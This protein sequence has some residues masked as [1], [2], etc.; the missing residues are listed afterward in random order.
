MATEHVAIT[1]PEIHEMK[2][3][4]AA[5]TGT[6]PIS[7]GAGSTAFA[8]IGSANINTSSI[9]NTNQYIFTVVLDD[10]ST[11]SSVYIGF[12]F[13]CTITSVVS[14]LQAAISGADALITFSNNGGSTAG[15]ITVAQSGSAAGDVDTVTLAANNTF[16]AAQRMQIATD[17]AST[18]TAK[19]VISLLATRTA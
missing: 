3:A 5:S 16:T 10:V 2:G 17:G 12:P 6:V 18:G 1:D 7:D 15:T 13:A 4:A 9:F 19:L 11:A 14:V 8:K